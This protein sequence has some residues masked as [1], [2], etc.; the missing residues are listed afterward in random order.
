MFYAIHVT[1]LTLK[2]EEDLFQA[3]AQV[4][5]QILRTH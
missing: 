4:S 2:F 3:A 1:R 5:E